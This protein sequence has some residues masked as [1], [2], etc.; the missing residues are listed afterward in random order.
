MIN[1]AA[2]FSGGELAERFADDRIIEEYAYE[3]VYSLKYNKILNGS[4]N[5]MLRPFDAATRAEAAVI[6]NAVLQK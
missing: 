3:D 1:R 2:D 6:I 5:N 4:D